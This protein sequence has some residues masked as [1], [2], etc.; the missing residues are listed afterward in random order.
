MVT[1]TRKFAIRSCGKSGAANQLEERENDASFASFSSKKNSCRKS[2]II[3]NYGRDIQAEKADLG[4]SKAAAASGSLSS[5]LQKAKIS[6]HNL[7]D[8]HKKTTTHN[9]LLDNEAECTNAPRK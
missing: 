8:S 2:S 7:F 9:M 4:K 5:L 6:S 1:P 3:K